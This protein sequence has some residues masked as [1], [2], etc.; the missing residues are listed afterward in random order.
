MKKLS[1]I[2]TMALVLT[3]VMGSQVMAE[4]PVVD[5]EPEY[6]Q[7]IVLTDPVLVENP[8]DDVDI[9][10]DFDEAETSYRFSVEYG[11]DDIL[12]TPDVVEA[13]IEDLTF[14]VVKIAEPDDV[15]V[16]AVDDS[17][18]IPLSLGENHFVVTVVDTSLAEGSDPVAVY[19]Y[20]IVRSPLEDM[21]AFIG[22]EEIAAFEYDSAEYNYEISTTTGTAVHLE[23]VYVEG[24]TAT[25]IGDD[26]IDV[27]EADGSYD[28][29]N[30]TFGNNLVT[31]TLTEVLEEGSVDVAQEIQYTLN[32]LVSPLADLM[33]LVGEDEMTLDPVFMSDILAYE[34]FLPYTVT[35]VDLDYALEV[36]DTDESVEAYFFTL[37]S[38]DEEV[39]LTPVIVGS[40]V[41][42]FDVVVGSNPVYLKVIY[43]RVVEE[44]T[45]EEVSFTY[46]V[47]VMVGTILNE[48]N[49]YDGD[50]VVDDKPVLL[51]GEDFESARLSY[52][53]T[54]PYDTASI[55][56]DTLPEGMTLRLVEQYGVDA[57]LDVVVP[58]EDGKY[59]LDNPGTYTLEVTVDEDIMYDIVIMKPTL[60]SSLVLDP[61]VEGFDFDPETMKY[62]LEYPEDTTNITVAAISIFEEATVK[63]G[64]ND[65]EVGADTEE[66]ELSVGKNYLNIIVSIDEVETNYRLTIYV[67]DAATQMD[68][69]LREYSF[70]YSEMHGTYEDHHYSF[71]GDDS[72]YAAI[73]AF[74]YGSN[75]FNYIDLTPVEGEDNGGDAEY[76]EIS[77]AMY[78]Y[79]VQHK[80]KL[81]YNGE[82]ID[83][84]SFR[85][86]STIK[87]PK[88]EMYVYIYITETGFEA[89]LV[90]IEEEAVETE[91]TPSVKTNPGKGNKK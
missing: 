91:A 73:K 78:K 57:E 22:D 29:D 56:V 77:Y 47:D 40:K 79:L 58:M 44:K 61:S 15:V 80:V 30:L 23:L 62:T 81:L 32:I 60:L 45:V 87:D 33:V 43:S 63:I 82:V 46:E 75:R 9:D 12:L 65:P 26:D 38:E 7:D 14:E 59:L 1:L 25:V 3:F 39:E 19:D 21:I 27:T 24:F 6:L 28:I 4:E 88:D 86:R 48:L 50:K 20:V 90:K 69:H 13:K 84:K 64:K 31:V 53:V 72:Y 66:V 54:V 85:L 52:E 8:E 74:K 17:Y 16:E 42:N 10:Y 36:L 34:T 18:P 41:E 71:D 51:F 70:E 55:V 5:P 89:S 67:G 37:N 49:I 83:L 35:Q 76:I 2:M 68:P 11:V